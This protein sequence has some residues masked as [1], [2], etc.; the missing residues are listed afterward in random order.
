[1]LDVAIIGGGLCGLALA[2]SL[3]ARRRD[4]AL[5]EARPR[6]GG[7]ILSVPT[8]HGVM[9]DL[10]PTWY[11]PERHPS[12]TRL[13]ADLQ[14]ASVAQADDGRVTLLDDANRPPRTLPFDAARG[15]L[16]EHAVPQPGAL[17]AG[18]RRLVG[19][20]GALVD[21]LRRPLPEAKLYLGCS[22]TA[23]TL[24]PD[25]VQL[26]LTEADG[27][28][29]RLSARHVV[30]ALP[31]RVAAERLRYT[32]ALSTEVALAMA[33][34]PTWMA[35]A[36][37]AVVPCAAAPWRAQPGQGN[38]WVTHA[39]AVLA[40]SWD[41][42]DPAGGPAAVAGFVA[43]APADRQRFASGMALLL[44]SQVSMLHGAEAG[45]GRPAAPLWHDWAAEPTTCSDTDRIDPAESGPHPAY[46]NPQLQL[47]LWQGR[48]WLGG[49][50]TA[51]QGGGYLEGALAAA[52]RLRR[53]LDD[54]FAIPWVAT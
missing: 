6:L 19:G 8:G 39:Q 49:S 31:P 45:A 28:E 23:L 48:L 10:G 24:Q 5:F 1:M 51:R 25:H 11:W 27:R 47:P 43:M 7:R 32:P 20:M 53:Q 52:A 26:T 29:R 16:D 15:G 46:G 33:E 44:E 17:H 30:L 18:A 40:E 42:G 41:A 13:V 50:E 22:V 4:W 12:L 38:A 3:Q 21:A 34:T 35:H 36:A 9:A 14:L 54:A 2:H 37:K